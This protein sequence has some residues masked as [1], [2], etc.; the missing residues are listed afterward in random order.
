MTIS[1]LP[2]NA[3][4]KQVMDKFEEISF[5]DFS[6]MDIITSTELP[7]TVKNGRVVIITSINP[8]NI[9]CS[10]F[11]N[12]F[13]LNEG[14]INIKLSDNEKENIHILLR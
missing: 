14:D 6:S 4:L 11:Y 3:S 8:E 7:S 2:A 1:K 9:I 5:Q 13:E 10:F 12:D